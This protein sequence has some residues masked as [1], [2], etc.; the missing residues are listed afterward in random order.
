MLQKWQVPKGAVNHGISQSSSFLLLCLKEHMLDIIGTRILVMFNI[1]AVPFSFRST[2]NCEAHTTTYIH[3]Y[4]VRTSPLHRPVGR[5]C[6][7]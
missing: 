5:L 6:R 1:L 7:E 2:N 4:N 3:T